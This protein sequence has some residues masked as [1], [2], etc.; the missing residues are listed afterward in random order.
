MNKKLFAPASPLFPALSLRLLLSSLALCLF[1]GACGDKQPPA[2]AQAPE[3][4][5]LMGLSGKVSPEAETLFSRAR[6]LWRGS[7]AS[8]ST[9]AEVC[10]DPEE[11]VVLLDK[12][13]ALEPSYA[14]AFVR[15]G[16]A[17]S[18]LGMREEAFAD[19]TTGIRLH[20]APEF[21]AYRGLISMRAR[22]FSAARK[23]LDYSLQLAP[24]QYLAWN[25]LGALGLM[26]GDPAAACRAFDKGC[27]A[28]DCSRFDVARKEG[29]CK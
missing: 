23:D 1:L 27:S 22:A 26:E 15:R 7:Q 29:V 2:P 19:A 14:E 13:I 11:A 9:T 28:G 5:N 24:S 20:P 3:R 4:Q 17:K 18:E 10:S 8:S 25:L 16:L 21:Y 12:A 6:V